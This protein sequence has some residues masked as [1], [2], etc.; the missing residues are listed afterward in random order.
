MKFEELDGVEIRDEK[1]KCVT[2]GKKTEYY[3]EDLD[4]YVCCYECAYKFSEELMIFL[5]SHK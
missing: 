3:D 5:D 2:C 4:E 1:G